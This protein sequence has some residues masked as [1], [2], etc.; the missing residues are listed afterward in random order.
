M[1][2]AWLSRDGLTPSHRLGSL[3]AG[4]VG[5]RY[6]ACPPSLRER[7]TKVPDV[8]MPWHG[9][10]VMLRGTFGPANQPVP[11]RAVPGQPGY[12]AAP[13]IRSVLCCPQCGDAIHLQYCVIF[14]KAT[15]ACI[16]LVCCRRFE[17]DN[18][19]ALHERAV[20]NM[21]L[22]GLG[23]AGAAGWSDMEID[24][25][26]AALKIK[27]KD[28]AFMQAMLMPHKTVMAIVNFY[29]NVWKSRS[30]LKAINWYRRVE[31]VR[32]SAL[33][34]HLSTICSLLYYVALHANV[35]DCF[36]ALGQRLSQASTVF[37][38][39]LMCGHVL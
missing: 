17:T 38:D 39:A 6:Q 19:G 25:F 26:E 1:V 27:G 33:T 18:K 16:T 21:G 30:I 13:I 12:V 28:F 10:L 7:P 15:C 34:R 11:V 2:L 14:W 32:D 9:V 36:L 31:Q 3:T 20:E 37:L 22:S 4:R 23:A 29:Y 24:L 35:H 5:Y 8:E